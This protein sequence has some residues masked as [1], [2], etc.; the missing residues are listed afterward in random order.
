MIV[1]DK[2]QRTNRYG[3]SWHSTP[4][5]PQRPEELSKQ[6]PDPGNPEDSA[7][8]GCHGDGCRRGD[9]PL[10]HFLLQ[11]LADVI[12]L[13]L[14]AFPALLRRKMGEAL[15]V[16]RLRRDGS[17]EIVSL[18]EIHTNTQPHQHHKI[19]RERRQP[20]SQQ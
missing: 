19:S 3:Y 15:R 12:D 20:E 2:R 5:I 9:S 16:H 6:S 1:K 17:G 10:I 13:L 8:A 4:L 11:L 14:Q 18:T 7:V